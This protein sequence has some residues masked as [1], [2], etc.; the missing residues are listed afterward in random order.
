MGGK[1]LRIPNER[2]LIG[3]YMKSLKEH[4]A[5]SGSSPKF[6]KKVD[7]YAIRSVYLC[8]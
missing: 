6:F 5:T 2:K 7:S 4:W 1:G 8:K 3:K